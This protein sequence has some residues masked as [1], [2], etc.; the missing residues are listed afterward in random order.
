MRVASFTLVCACLCTLLLSGC[1]DLRRSSGGGETRF[2]PPRKVQ[3]AD[4]AVPAG[5]RVEVLATG[6][7]F[8]TG[9]AIDEAGQPFVIEAGYSYGEVFTQPRLLL[10]ARDGS[11]REVAAGARN[12][13]WTGVAHHGGAFYI[14]EGGQIDGGRILRVTPDGATQTL[15]EGLPGMG[16][17]HTNG[18]AIAADGTLYIGQGTATNAGVVG[19]DNAHYGWLKRHPR[20]HDIP[21]RDIALAGEN[22][23]SQDVVAGTGRASTGA[24]LPFGT[25][26]TPGQRIPGQVPCSGAILRLPPGGALEVV[27]WGFRNPFGLA[28]SPQGELYVTENGYDDRG[29]RPVWGVP[30]VLWRVQP[31]AWYGWPDYAAGRPLTNPDFRPRHKP[32]PRFLLAQHPAAPP[33]PA[34]LLGVH[35]SSNG[36]DFSRSPTFGH[37][38]EAFIAQFGDLGPE[39]GKVLAPV[40]YKVV[41]VD[42]QTGVVHDFAVNRGR[43][44]GPAS[45]IGGAGFERPVAARFDAKGDALYVVDFGV[46]LQ[47][48]EV[49]LPQPHTGVLWRITRLPSQ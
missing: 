34:A 31:G 11:V 15:V 1:Y 42:P 30:D 4:V 49:S 46:F 26:S 20:F 37:V 12:G 33:A 16:D 24:F 13:P 35:S 43:V 45:K 29:S 48:G 41:R 8:P 44:N 23:E 36:L 5:Y 19:E 25:P 9:V 22:F 10:V 21:C 3:A 32:Q 39:T 28:F 2:A 14:A 27:A 18:P 38:G 6:L 17:H 40:G 47:H 7:T